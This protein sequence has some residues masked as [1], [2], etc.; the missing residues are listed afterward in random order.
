MKK[1][2]KCN[3]EL[4]SEAHFCPKC[5]YEYPRADRRRKRRNPLKRKK[6]V[7]I[8]VFLVSV[9]FLHI[10]SPLLRPLIPKDN[11]KKTGEQNQ[12]SI[13]MTF[14]TNEMSIDNPAIIH[15]FEDVLL[16]DLESVSQIL[17]EEI[18][19]A[20]PD[21]EYMVHEF[22]SVEIEVSQDERVKSI[23]VDYL[24]ATDEIIEQYGIHGIN[25]KTS[26]EEVR[27][28]I[29]TPDQNFEEE[30]SYR[31]DG[32]RGMP[33]LRVFFDENDM[34]TALQYYTLQ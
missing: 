26:R 28:R 11:G 16:T 4:P 23:Y 33:T 10:L 8:I 3:L 25:G 15:D 13:E 31:F 5:M 19:E 12:Q 27:G 2:P 32:E 9:A 20:Y 34:V 6:R 30:W 18:M 22:E 29:G 14:R 17:G 1:C 24:N 7:F 21:E